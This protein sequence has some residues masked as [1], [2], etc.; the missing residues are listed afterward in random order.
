MRNPT[1]ISSREIFYPKNFY[2]NS[3]WT[4]CSFLF[5]SNLEFSFPLN[6]PFCKQKKNFF[7]SL[8]LSHTKMDFLIKSFFFTFYRLDENLHFENWRVWM[9]LLKKSWIKGE[10]KI[11]KSIHYRHKNPPEPLCKRVDTK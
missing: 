10:R 3:H 8:L 5:L 9:N 7:S 1:K 6:C 11:G 4:S 2:F